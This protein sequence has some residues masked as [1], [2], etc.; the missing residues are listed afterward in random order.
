MQSSTR[1]ST[2]SDVSPFEPS[3][4]SFQTA[5]ECIVIAHLQGVLRDEVKISFSGNSL[6]LKITGPSDKE[7]LARMGYYSHEVSR[8]Y[9][10][11]KTVQF[12][13]EVNAAEAKA[14]FKHGVLEVRVPKLIKK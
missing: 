9:G 7:Q 10:Y 3:V 1:F 2:D 11:E 14:T 12:P 5:S 4:E 6:T 8:W 13:V